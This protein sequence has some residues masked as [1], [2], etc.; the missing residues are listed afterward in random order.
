MTI[1]EK[2]IE[3]QNLIEK[4]KEK[5]EKTNLFY[6]LCV[7]KSPLATST[8]CHRTGYFED[9]IECINFASMLEK[10]YKEYFYPFYIVSNGADIIDG[11][12]LDKDD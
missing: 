5:S 7:W 10:T 8:L 9:V 6:V 2:R 12:L 1:T 3:I 11:G 4:K